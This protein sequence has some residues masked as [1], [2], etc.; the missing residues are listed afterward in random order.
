[1]SEKHAVVAV[2]TR[3]AVRGTAPAQ[4]NFVV[5]PFHFALS[6]AALLAST[7]LAF[8]Q[9]PPASS[10]GPSFNSYGVALAQNNAAIEQARLFRESE[11]APRSSVDANGN[12]TGLS[13]DNSSP[14]DDSFGAQLILKNQEMPRPYTVTGGISLFHT[15]NAALTRTGAH[16]DEFAVADASF[17]WSPKL[18]NNL[19]ATLGV[20][21]ALFRYFDL[22]ELNFENLGATAGLAW[23][24]P[25][26]RG[27][28][29]FGRYDFT[30]LLSSDGDQILMEHN[31]TMGLQK[32]IA[33]G[34]SHGVTFGLLGIAGLSD[35]HAAQRD[36]VAAF[37]AY[38]VRLTRSLEADFLVRPAIHFY[39]AGGRTD[40]NQILS[41]SLRYRFNQWADAAAF[42]S[43]GWNRSD[44][45]VFDYDVLTAGGGVAVTIRF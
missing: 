42:L 38:H 1:M 27:F 7:S 11:P 31:L 34:R 17:G 28:S 29:L 35:P 32:T 5:S 22:P 4:A 30:E 37:L 16:A 9:Q 40:F 45:T 21:A 43:Y 24:P 23:N 3:V 15:D 8:S 14:G 44:K 18:G 33:F 6:T 10:S 20:H 13:T 2:L 41:G 25:A 12:Q 19:E 36:Q 39:N 26:L